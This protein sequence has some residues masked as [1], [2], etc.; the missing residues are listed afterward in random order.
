MASEGTLHVMAQDFKGG[1]WSY[2]G[3][4]PEIEAWL[5]KRGNHADIS[6]IVRDD[7]NVT[8]GRKHFGQKEITWGVQL[9]A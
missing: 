6:V 3:T 1:N 4:R 5:E 9:D 7:T 2:H 8:V